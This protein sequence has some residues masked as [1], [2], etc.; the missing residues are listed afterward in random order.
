ML[1]GLIGR[2][3]PHIRLMFINGEHAFLFRHHSIGILLPGA[4]G[5]SKD[6]Q[7]QR[8]GL[9]QYVV[10]DFLWWMEVSAAS[11]RTLPPSTVPY[12]TQWSPACVAQPGG[13]YRTGYAATACGQ[14]SVLGNCRALSCSLFQQS[15]RIPLRTS[16]RLPTVHSRYA[17]LSSSTTA[18]VSS[19]TS[20]L[21]PSNRGSA[22]LNG[23]SICFMTFCAGTALAVG[24]QCQKANF[25]TVAPAPICSIPIS[26]CSSE[27]GC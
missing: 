13:S 7:L 8:R 11:S 1:H 4:A 2:Y 3:H 10:P 22:G 25:P 5:P 27:Q 17:A 18:P 9:T 24:C 20:V 19:D 6:V 16:R 12:T 21:R 23:F 14:H 26:V 15:D